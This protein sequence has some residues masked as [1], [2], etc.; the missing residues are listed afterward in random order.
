[1]EL[2]RVLVEAVERTDLG[3]DHRGGLIRWFSTIPTPAGRSDW[4]FTEPNTWGTGRP[5]RRPRLTTA[6]VASRQSTSSVEAGRQ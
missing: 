5:A 1:V 2:K 3:D 6:H 4:T